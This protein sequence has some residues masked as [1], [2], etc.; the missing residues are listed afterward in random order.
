MYSQKYECERTL[1]VSVKGSCLGFYIHAGLGGIQVEDDGIWHNQLGPFP[2]A[3]CVDLVCLLKEVSV[4]ELVPCQSDYFVF[5][6][7]G[8]TF[9]IGLMEEHVRTLSD[10]FQ[11]IELSRERVVLWV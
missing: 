9:I 6:L 2:L 11:R 5:D 3:V 10:Y 7:E 4:F 1:N 8:D